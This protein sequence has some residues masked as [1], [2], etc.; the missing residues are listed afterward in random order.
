MHR[1][2][3]TKQKIDQHQNYHLR[4]ARRI[5]AVAGQCSSPESG[6]P[7]KVKCISE[8]KTKEEQSPDREM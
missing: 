4:I 2:Y 1:Y 3:I 6:L 8:Q 7:I 5:R